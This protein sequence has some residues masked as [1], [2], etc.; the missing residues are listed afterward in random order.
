MRVVFDKD[1]VVI[2]DKEPGVTSEELAR[3]LGRRLVHRIDRDTSG[4]L[5]LADDARTVTRFQRLMREGRV[6]RTYCFV[7]NGVVKAGR[8]E[9]LL[10]RDRGD[11]LRGSVRVDTA[12]AA[13]DAAKL[14]IA[15][16]SGCVVANDERTTTCIVTLVTGRTHQIRIQ[17]AEDGHPLVGERIYVRDARAASTPLLESSR[18]LLHAARLRFPHPNRHTL[19]DVASAVPVDFERVHGRGGPPAPSRSCP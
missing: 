15:E 13:R 9:S 1:R 17:L 8:R 4:L 3:V 7:A 2:V 6:E 12:P 5:V 18:L 11:G 16:V 10:A 19:V 14:A